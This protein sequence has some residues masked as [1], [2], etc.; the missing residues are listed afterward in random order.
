[1]EGFL[2]GKTLQGPAQFQTPFSWIFLKPEG[3]R[4]GRRKGIKFWFHFFYDLGLQFFKC[5][6]TSIDN[7]F[8]SLD[9]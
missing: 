4:V 6:P 7:D 1:M 5:F 2:A 9:G 3:N 8:S